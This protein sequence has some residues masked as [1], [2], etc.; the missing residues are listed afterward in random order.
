MITIK[1][2]QIDGFDEQ[3]KIFSLFNLFRKCN[4]QSDKDR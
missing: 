4:F 1:D 3:M 2:K